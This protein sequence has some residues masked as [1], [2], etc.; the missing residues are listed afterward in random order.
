MELK[1]TENDL[2]NKNTSGI[3][4]MI[5]NEN[6]IIRGVWDREK[7]L[8]GFVINEKDDLSYFCKMENG[9][10]K[11]LKQY[12]LS[13]N[14]FNKDDEEEEKIYDKTKYAYKTN[15]KFLDYITLWGEYNFPDFLGLFF[16]DY[17]DIGKFVNEI[18]IGG[19][20]D[21]LKFVIDYNL[22]TVTNEN[23]M[24]AVL[25]GHLDIVKLICE[26][27][28]NKYDIDKCKKISYDNMYTELSEYL[29]RL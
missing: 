7:F 1:Y 8:F 12:I 20:Y 29:E 15:D 27:T 17:V 23:L 10:L 24:N 26:K 25:R 19:W 14:K 2:T 13:K 28:N 16:A 22:G 3:S 18:C 11:I 21:A 5:I 6:V 4:Q 9:E